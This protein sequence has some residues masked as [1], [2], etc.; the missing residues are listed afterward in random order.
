MGRDYRQKHGVYFIGGGSIFTGQSFI[1]T[2][3]GERTD[4]FPFRVSYKEPKRFF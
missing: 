3:C 2:R 4:E 1:I